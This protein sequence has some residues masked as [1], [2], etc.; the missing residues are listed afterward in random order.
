MAL[1]SAPRKMQA[2]P[3]PAQR[4]LLISRR[5]PFCEAPCY[6]SEEAELEPINKRGGI[7]S[8]FAA[9]SSNAI[10]PPLSRLM[11]NQQLEMKEK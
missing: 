4:K 8:S 11:E 10:P 2:P 1:A 7:F 9:F 5:D 6:F 3:R